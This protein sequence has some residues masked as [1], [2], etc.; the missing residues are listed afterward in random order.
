MI[1]SNANPIGKNVVPLILQPLEQNTSEILRA[2]LLSGF[3]SLDDIPRRYR[4]YLKS[5]GL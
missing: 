1:M 2:A 5:D 3:R 4:E